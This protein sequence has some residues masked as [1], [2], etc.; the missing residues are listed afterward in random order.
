MSRLIG[1]P[2]GCEYGAWCY[3]GRAYGDITC[4][5]WLREEHDSSVGL[6]VFRRPAEQLLEELLHYDELE[7][8]RVAELVASLTFE[9]PEDVPDIARMTAEGARKFQIDREEACA[10]YAFQVA[11]TTLERADVA[12]LVHSWWVRSGARDDRVSW[13]QEVTPFVPK[14][15]DELCQ[16]EWS[17]RGKIDN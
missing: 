5:P 1:A 2:C 9:Y 16:G 8:R 17:T 4:P 7:R 12:R 15:W 11:A 3:C 14:T 6:G 13:H 10:D